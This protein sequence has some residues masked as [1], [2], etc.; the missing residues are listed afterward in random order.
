[1]KLTFRRSAALATW[2][3]LCLAVPAQDFVNYRGTTGNGIYPGVGLLKEWPK[4]GP[5]LLWTFNPGDGWASPSVVDGKVYVVGSRIGQLWTLDLDGKPV[6]RRIQVGSMEWKRF[7]GSRGVP[8]IK[9][10]VAVVNAPNANYWGIDLASGA[11]R[12][13]VNAWKSFGDGQGGMGWGCPESPMLIDNKVVFNTCSRTNRQPAIVA[14]DIATGKTVWGMDTPKKYSAADVS[15]SWGVHKGR[16]LY[17]C[18]TWAWFICLDA[19]TGELLWE[20]PNGGEATLVPMYNDGHIL[21]GD[22]RGTMH[23]MRLSDDAKT[24]RRLWSRPGSYGGWSQA[25]CVD[26]RIFTFSRRNMQAC[27]YDDDG[28]A[29]T[30]VAGI[31]ETTADKDANSRPSLICLDRDT[32]RTLM[33]RPAPYW[34]GH[35]IAADGMVYV[36]EVEDSTIMHVS[37]IKPTP[38]GF[39][40][41]SSFQYEAKTFDPYEANANTAIYEGR[42]FIRYGGLRCFDLRADIPFTG[43]RMDGSGIFRF[44]SP[45][46]RWSL[47][48]NFAWKKPLPS[49]GGSAPVA[50]QGKAF[51]TLDDGTLTCINTTDGQTVWS[52]PPPKGNH[53][54]P[55]IAANPHRML[56]APVLRATNIYAALPDGSVASYRMDGTCEWVTTLGEGCASAAPIPYR[57]FIV[58]PGN[59]V[60]AL[61][62]KDGKV[63]WTHAREE[64]VDSVAPVYAAGKP[65]LVTDT[66]LLLDL[67]D[68][69][70]LASNLFD[71]HKAQFVT[72]DARNGRVYTVSK[73]SRRSFPAFWS[74]KFT[75][76]SVALP[77]T[78]NLAPRA[79]WTVR[80]K[81]AAPAT[82]PIC[83]N[84]QLYIV[85]A[86]RVLVVLDTAT[87]TE[88]A[89]IALDAGRKSSTAAEPHMSVA[90]RRLYV[91]N[92]GRQNLTVVLQPGPEPTVLWQYATENPSFALAFQDDAQLV[93]AGSTLWCMRGR[94]PEEPRDPQVGSIEPQPFLDTSELKAPVVPFS[95][96]TVPDR[97]LLA[98]PCFPSSLLTNFLSSLGPVKDL[99][100][101]EG[102]SVRAGYTTIV[103]RPSEPK[104]FWESEHSARMRA[105]DYTLMTS[106]KPGTIHAY[107]V[108]ENDRDRYVEYNP[109][110]PGQYWRDF[111]ETLAAKSWLS[112]VPIDQG[113]T[114]LLKKGRHGLL[115]Q[116]AVGRP[117]NDWGKIFMTPH[118]IDVEQKTREALAQYAEDKVFWAEY[119]RTRDERIVLRH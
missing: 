56:P 85:C 81:G 72:T 32:G 68:G 116:A 71:N 118:L 90:G 58:L 46:I 31:A 108:I 113:S 35:I 82:P 19:D 95:D 45:P 57:D 49:T 44:A 60:T 74:R 42:L 38:D 25:V 111:G 66:G 16:K 9:D 64:N 40:Q 48:R 21:W 55:P 99:S 28:N 13:Q 22:S 50:A 83:H 70:P 17:F 18:P 93:R 29:I 34:P 63:V 73:S 109:I 105:F 12:W 24:Y 76:R 33:G 39:E 104:D 43:E 8:L 89:R 1:M 103:F 112:G 88:S 14:L 98:G 15:G 41:V 101:S 20:L 78:T 84:G 92:V 75:A 37:L 80:I 119:A 102:Q 79:E 96:K 4:E 69:K 62:A 26:N 7:S 114:F 61:N 115:I 106:R 51:L 36:T 97:W 94:T 100:L 47:T 67:S 11:V 117:W 2:S 91:Q 107:T 110:C 10:G 27:R 3:A 77:P 87:G 30:N 86:D 5:K 6:G 52:Q 65:A 23:M 54:P 59:G 53:G